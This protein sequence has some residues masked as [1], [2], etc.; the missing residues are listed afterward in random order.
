[1]VYIPDPT[2]ATQPTAS[3]PAQS[4]AAEFRALK[5]Y[6]QSVLA[7]IGIGGINFFRKNKIQNG[8]FR[9]DQRLEG[10][11]TAVGSGL[12]CADR[13]YATKSAASTVN[14]QR[15]AST[16][17][18]GS[19]F[20]LSY[21]VGSAGSTVSGDIALIKQGIE[22]KDIADLQWGT[23]NAKPVSVSFLY[24]SAVAGTH[25][26]S[27][28]NA[29][30]TRSYVATFNVALANTVYYIAINN[31]PGDGVAGAGSWATDDTLGIQVNIDT[32]SG[33][34]YEAAAAN[35]WEAGNYTRVS[36]AVKI[37]TGTGTTSITLFQLEQAAAASAYDWQLLSTELLIAQR[38]FWKTYP[39]GTAVGTLTISNAAGAASCEIVLPLISPTQTN[40][41]GISGQVRFPT[42][43][44]V[45]PAMTYLSGETASSTAWYNCVAGAAG[46]NISTTSGY[47]TKT[48]FSL[49]QNWVHASFSGGKPG[50][51]LAINAT[52][53][54][55]F[56]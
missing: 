56:F 6:L 40:D 27:F 25:C 41:D 50:D 33:A 42:S 1:M 19:T 10:V 29:A 31:I 53:N 37:C 43:M 20:M 48:A 35:T 22:G 2:D 7:G 14:T 47:V 23:V 9:L 11:S 16:L 26:I 34:T 54:A 15:V 38:Y 51:Q 52:A 12:Y 49:Y 32:G 21:I 5:G 28:Q 39:L 3:Q 13:F 18:G 30:K 44:R 24:S 8:D 45:T 17:G 36:G 46:P 55:D 4:A